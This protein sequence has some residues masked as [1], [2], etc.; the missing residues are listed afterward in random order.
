M[1]HLSLLFT[2]TLLVALPSA[3]DE[4]VQLRYL[5]IK[6][7]ASLSITHEI[8]AGDEANIHAG[9]RFLMA[10]EFNT[11]PDLKTVTITI[12]K[13][14]GSSTAHEMTQRLSTNHLEGHSFNFLM[15]DHLSLQQIKTQ[16][17]FAIDLGRAVEGGFPINQTL[18]DLFPALP[19]E[20]VNVG[21]SWTDQRTVRSLEGWA[22]ATGSVTS[23]HKVTA[24]QQLNA[25]TIISVT[26]HSNAKLESMDDMPE[27]SFDGDLQ[28]TRDWKFD[29]T[30][31]RL[32][33]LSMQ[34]NTKGINAFPQAK[35]QLQQLTE[36]AFSS[37]D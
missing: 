23:Q 32:L 26:T 13:I 27:Y 28:Q 8:T 6:G 16:E 15:N 31:G 35:L 7:Q 17:H 12:G 5:D 3:A 1:K 18:Y 25:H 19:T 24:I 2:T 36:V 11:D 34:Q 14:Q 22:W 33:A 30:G 20:P 4:P 29:A 37:T 10:F 9:R 21:S